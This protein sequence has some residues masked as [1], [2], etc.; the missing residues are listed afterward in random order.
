[1]QTSEA[2]DSVLPSRSK[3]KGAA[4]AI[5]ICALTKIYEIWKSPGS[6]LKHLFSQSLARRL[7]SGSGVRQKLER[8]GDRYCR[9]FPALQ[10][11]SFRVSPGESVGIIGRNGSGKSTL[12][13]LIAGTLQPT[14][15][16]VHVS[17]RLTALLELGSG[18]N[19]DFTGRE[20]VYLN[21]ALLGIPDEEVEQ[22]FPEILDFADIGAF[23][24]QP[25]RTYSSGMVVRLAFAVNTV[26]RPD[27]VIVDE[28]L[29]V[30]DVFFQ[31]KCHQRLKETMRH[32]TKLI[33]THDMHA[34]RNLAERV[35]VLEQG[36]IV[37]DGPP[38]DAI[39]FYL[40]IMQ[41]ASLVSDDG[42]SR[43]SEKDPEEDEAMINLVRTLRWVDVP[44]SALSGR[45]EVIIE[46]LALTD[47]GN[48][49]MTIA[50]PEQIVSVHALVEVSKAPLNIVAGYIL[51]DR[52]GNPVCGENT[53]S[54]Q[55]DQPVFAADGRHY[56]RF[57]FSWPQLRPG[58]Y[59]LTVGLGSGNHPV[60]HAIQCWAHNVASIKGISVASDQESFLANPLLNFDH[61]LLTPKR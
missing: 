9:Y 53:F 28:A 56:F 33:V 6:R 48:E 1:M 49:P 20:N 23:I 3:E 40:K 61:S 50:E 21:A 58:E 32:A 47:G 10:D 39:A 7:P 14:R 19:P 54:L 37:F 18:F 51:R 25:V 43:I 45:K 26:V 30:G 5:E 44:A 35:I 17:G 27:I 16:S 15:G 38:R 11:L 4:T 36:K 46:K 2:T 57:S 34:L 59:T 22:L 52:V 24:D 29:A 13:Q 42:C 12:L 55:M 8:L 31:Q 60:H 41:D